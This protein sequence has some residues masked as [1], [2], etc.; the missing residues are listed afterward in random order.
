M[1]DVELGQSART[2]FIETAQQRRRLLLAAMA[3][4]DESDQSEAIS[5]LPIDDVAAMTRL[6]REL[7]SQD[8]DG[9][10]ISVLPSRI[11]QLRA[12]R[13]QVAAEKRVGASSLDAG[14]VL[15]LREQVD[16]AVTSP[17]RLVYEDEL[18][19]EST[20]LEQG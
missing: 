17:D 4:L 14:L 11:A 6:S 12:E 3:Y 18:T 15:R 20:G 1:T 19:R 13:E 7:S 9:R 2:T 8:T 10:E 16:A 5:D